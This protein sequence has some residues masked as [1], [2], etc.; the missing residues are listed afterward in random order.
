MGA[1]DKTIW[2][3]AAEADQIVVTRDTDFLHMALADA[4]G[5]AVVLVRCGNL[6]L[7]AFERWFA[8]RYPTMMS[9]LGGGERIVEL[10]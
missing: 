1:L 5:P 3:A 4:S 9:A 2:R 7:R 6:G 10:A 8:L